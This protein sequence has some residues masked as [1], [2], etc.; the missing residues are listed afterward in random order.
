MTQG[1]GLSE[2]ND[3]GLRVS[4][5]VSTSAPRWPEA[6]EMISYWRIWHIM[7]AGITYL[8]ACRTGF[9]YRRFAKMGR[10]PS[11]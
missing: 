2:K 10:H 3:G 9:Y 7:L 8:D 5:I 4:G 11:L 1:E 6:A